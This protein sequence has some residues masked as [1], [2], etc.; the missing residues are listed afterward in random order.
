MASGF[1][2]IRRDVDD[3]F[4]R[5]RMPILLTKIE[6]KGNGLKTVLPN[7]SNVA[8]AL[9]RPPSY[10]TKF[11]GYE[12]GAHI[13]VD[14][15]KER[16]I[17]N[18]VHDANRLRELLHDFIDKFVLCK[19][20][21]NPETE[22]IVLKVGR[23]EDIIQHCKACGERKGVNMGHKLTT[24]ILKNPPIK[25]RQ[26]KKVANGDAVEGDNEPTKKINALAEAME[27]NQDAAIEAVKARETSM[28]TAAL[29]GGYED[30]DEDDE[31][32]PYVQFGNFIMDAPETDN[33]KTLNTAIY[34]KAEELGIEKKHKAA[35]ILV[36]IFT[37]N[38]VAEIPKFAPLLKKA[39]L[40]G[41]E[42][43]VGLAY[44]GL[45]PQVTEILMALYQ[46]DILDQKV[47]TD[48]GTHVSKKY[49][50]KEVNKKVRR[51]GMRFFKWLEEADDHD[52]D[53][54][55]N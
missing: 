52:S 39:F 8:R 32:S 18:G 49:T 12:L 46:N 41:I 42:R 55:D 36:T 9:G 22:L 17:V 48:W 38:V 44:P 29:G 45:L 26:G 28:P 5:Y 47:V 43:L 20:C 40:G 51:A 54:D 11:F 16:Y 30:A 21:K 1:V 4:Y 34:K 27:L 14:D 23:T 37:E 7:M 35:L 2:N 19:L 24:F 10:T 6:G 25:A 53:E 50:D 3:Q 31:N 33:P 13:S 15:K